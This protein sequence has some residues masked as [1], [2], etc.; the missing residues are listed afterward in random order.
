M[1][2]LC[3]FFR[4]ITDKVLARILKGKDLVLKK[5]ERNLE[6]I[7]EEILELFHVDVFV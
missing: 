5:S 3:R 4:E 7:A 1:R 2:N 6:G